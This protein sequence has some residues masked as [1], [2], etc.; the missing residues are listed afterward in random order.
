MVIS[1]DAATNR[2]I[3]VAVAEDLL[4]LSSIHSPFESKLA[5]ELFVQ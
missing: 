3:Y 4:L 1:S 2:P 5:W